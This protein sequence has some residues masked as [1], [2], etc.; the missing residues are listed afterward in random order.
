MTIRL[1]ASHPPRGDRFRLPR[2]DQYPP[3]YS[4]RFKAV[5]EGFTEDGK[6]VYQEFTFEVE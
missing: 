3:A 1:M 6:P 2:G 5:A 4:G